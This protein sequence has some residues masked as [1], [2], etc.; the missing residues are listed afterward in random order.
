MIDTLDPLYWRDTEVTE[1]ILSQLFSLMEYNEN[2]PNLFSYVFF[3]IQPVYRKN[4]DSKNDNEDDNDNNGLGSRG[5]S[6][7]LTVLKEW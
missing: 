3:L 6:L 7:R 2:T 4:T 1:W 5:S